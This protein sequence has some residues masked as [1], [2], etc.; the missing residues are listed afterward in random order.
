[1]RIPPGQALAA[2]ILPFLAV[3][4]AQAGDD[5]ELTQPFAPEGSLLVK[6]ARGDFEIVG[7]DE[8]QVRVRGELDDLAT[9][10][11]FEV[12]G[13]K[14]LLRVDMPEQGVN[15]GDGSDLKIHVP[16]NI[17]LRVAVISA[18]VDLK[19]LGGDV[20][21]RT[22]SGEVE[23]ED[24]GANTHVKTTSG[25]VELSGASG[26]VRVVTTSG[27]AELEVDAQAVQ[28]DT[29]SGDIQLA[30]GN[31][32][33]VRANSISG[34]LDIRGTMNPAALLESSTVS[35]D[36]ELRLAGPIDVA[37]DCRT[38]PGGEIDNGFSRIEPIESP[39]GTTLKATVGDGLGSLRVS[40]VAG[41]IRLKPR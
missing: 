12:E 34:E 13:E 41:T 1:M 24:L 31:F 36:I 15:W 28:V 39:H 5:V 4:S 20:A 3:L 2:A 14:A 29:M 37:L 35:G 16:R 25:D 18:D 23:G 7:W 21:V 9:G 38:G 6:G 17:R 30:L 19:R 40:T 32:D 27:D 33:S 10:L 26:S 11:T 22:V 8:E